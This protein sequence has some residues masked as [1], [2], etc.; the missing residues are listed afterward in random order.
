MKKTILIIDDSAPIRFLL[1]AMLSKEYNVVSAADGF[2]ALT[3]L[4]KGN[5][6]DCI[7]TDLQMPNIDGWELLEYLSGSGLYQNIPVVVLSSQPDMEMHNTEHR[8]NNVYAFVQKPFDPMR[9]TEIVGQAINRP[10]MAIA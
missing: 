6:V 3:W 1:E 9:L 5:A 4:A 10:L 8:Y 7:I 2:V